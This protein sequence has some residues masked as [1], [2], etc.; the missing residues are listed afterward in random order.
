ML[1]QVL[2]YHEP[3]D[4]IQQKVDAYKPIKLHQ[5]ALHH[6]RQKR[7]CIPAGGAGAGA[8]QQGS[9]PPKTPEV[10]VELAAANKGLPAGWNAYRSRKE[11]GRIYWYSVFGESTWE[12]PT[13]SAIRHKK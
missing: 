9:D 3:V 2:H 1:P 10:D 13:V 4:Q 5:Q 11:N 8:G 12:R 7:S 6:P